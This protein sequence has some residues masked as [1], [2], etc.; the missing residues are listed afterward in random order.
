MATASVLR[1]RRQAHWGFPAAD[2]VGEILKRYQTLAVVGLSPRVTR[3]SYGVS[4]Y[5]RARGYQII[6][7]N[8]NAESVFGEKAYPSLEAVPGPVDIVVIFRKPEHVPAVVGSAISKGAK[9]VWMQ[10]GVIHEQAAARA[11]EAGL[12]VV[13][14]RCILKEYAKR[15]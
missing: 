11:R 1:E 5:M 6:P 3:P 12:V 8:P 10:E 13:Q 9:V 15:F 2:T 14:D 7:V 4:A